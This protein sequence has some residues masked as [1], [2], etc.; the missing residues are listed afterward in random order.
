MQKK[1]LAQKIKEKSQKIK[2]KSQKYIKKINERIA[3]TWRFFGSSENNPLAVEWSRVVRE[4]GLFFTQGEDGR[5]K[6]ANTEENRKKVA[7]L[8]NAVKKHNPRTVGQY[9]H[10]SR[11]ELYKEIEIEEAETGV[12]IPEPTQKEVEERSKL[13]ARIYRLSGL[14]SLYYTNFGNDSILQDLN[15]AQSQKNQSLVS[16]LL[17]EMELRIQQAEVQAHVDNEFDPSDIN[18]YAF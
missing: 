7:Q 8:E 17:D 16:Q 6:I 5:Y 2:E 18:K 13:K 12:E 11:D 10:E 9:H 14:I 4:S 3:A 1:S 15:S